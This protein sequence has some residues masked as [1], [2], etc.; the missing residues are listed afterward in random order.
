MRQ[1][2]AEQIHAARDVALG[3]MLRWTEARLANREPVSFEV[4]AA[5]CELSGDTLEYARGLAESAVK[6]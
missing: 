2:T 3:Y 4:Y 1:L 6:R 5:G